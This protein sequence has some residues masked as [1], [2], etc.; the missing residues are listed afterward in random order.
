M[1]A[2]GQQAPRSFLTSTYALEDV[3]AA[4]ASRDAFRP[5]PRAGEP[6]WDRVPEKVRD[7]HIQAAEAYLDQPWKPLPAT[8]FL[9][10]VRTG[11]RSNF[12]D[13]SFGRR[14]RLATL[15]LAE[16]MENQGRFMDEIVN[17]IWFISEE[18][19]WG[20]P[21]HLR[22]QKAGAGLPDVNEPTVDLFAAETGSLMAW[23]DYLVGDKLDAISPLIRT[24]LRAEVE[25]RILVPNYEREDFWWMGFSGGRVNNWN[26]W[27]NSNW[28]TAVLLLETDTD[29]RTQA[30]YKIMRS[31]DVF[32]DSYPEDGGCDEGPAYWGR[33]GGSLFDT[34]EL[35]YLATTGSIDIFD[36]PLI[37]Q[38]GK[39]IYRSYIAGSYFINFADAGA[40]ITPEAALVYRYGKYIE[41][42]TMMGFAAFLGNK[43]RLGQGYVNGRFG[44]IN[45]QLPALFTL[46]ELLRI[47]PREPLL[48][49]FWLPDTQV[50]AARDLAGS[51]EGFYVAMKG[52]HNDE[53]H[54]HNDIGHFIVYHNGFPVFIDVGAG[55]YTAQTFS[56]KRYSIWNMQSA[57]HNVPTI[58]GVMQQAGREFRARRPEFK[59]APHMAKLQIE[60]D[61]AYPEAAKVQ[62]WFR[63]LTTVRERYIEVRD[64]YLLE[65]WVAPTTLHFMT[66]RSVDLSTPGTIVLTAPQ[67]EGTLKPVDVKLAYDPEVV[68]V[69]LDPIALDD[70]KLIK[71]W[72]PRLYRISLKTKSRDLRGEVVVRISA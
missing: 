40:R 54:N 16:A 61:E 3:T 6:G 34:L 9:E 10:Y 23:T 25:R 26:P 65:A 41:D 53:S 21:A 20:V 43:S 14:E 7:A 52:G 49:G 11:N 24:R 68:E 72:G 62:S 48:P 36:K 47:E 33:A 69:T 5:Y 55:A 35:L 8:V 12:Q 60:I 56:S 64:Q 39:Y 44:A 32:I 59:T 1:P 2:N 46:E 66:P 15:V 58:N 27:V 30:V 38:M 31:L 4:L 37:A 29:R 70:A 28:L 18:T 67:T 17:G 42:E 63:T 13:L 71:G 51:R 19:Y 22:L 57:Y 45:R 50:M